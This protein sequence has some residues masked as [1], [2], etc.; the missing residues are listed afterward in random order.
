MCKPLWSGILSHAVQSILGYILTLSQANS[1]QVDFI[2]FYSDN[3]GH[4]SLSCL[5]AT[6]S[7]QLISVFSQ[8]LYLRPG[9]FKKAA[10]NQSV[11]IFSEVFWVVQ[12]SGGVTVPVCSFIS[13]I[14]FLALISVPVLAYFTSYIWPQDCPIDLFSS[15]LP[16]ASLS[17]DLSDPFLPIL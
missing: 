2:L 15:L 7:D 1:R 11:P 13:W 9:F 10:R 3:I 4:S 16:S 6:E 12:I 8:G 5:L 17:P 14:W